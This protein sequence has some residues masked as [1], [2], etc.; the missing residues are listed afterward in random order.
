MDAQSIIIIGN[1]LI[2]GATLIATL[3]RIKI[4]RDQIKVTIENT[5]SKRCLAV[6]RKHV[7][8]EKEEIVKM[9]KREL[10]EFLES[11]EHIGEE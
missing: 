1:T 5:E 7:K 6:L 3:Y 11:I 4:E 9:N 8:T 10:K 2:M